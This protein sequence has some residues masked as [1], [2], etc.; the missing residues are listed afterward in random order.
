MEEIRIK[1]GQGETVYYLQRKKIKSVNIRVKEDCRIYVSAAL[2]V[3]RDFID[4]FVLNNSRRIAERIEQIRK[5]KETAVPFRR[6]GQAEAALKQIYTETLSK[7]AH[8]FTGQFSLKIR[9]MK[10]RWGTY[11]SKKRAVTLNAKLI[12]A[13][14]ACVEYIVLHELCHSKFP[15]HGNDFYILLEDLMP[16]HKL[17]RKMLRE[18][19]GK[20]L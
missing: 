15:N 17:R 8:I 2:S 20:Y 7:Y 10:T 1:S 13:P 11:N 14:K 4:K 12:L 19:V 16:D 6:D 5:K 18:E 9:T 3:S